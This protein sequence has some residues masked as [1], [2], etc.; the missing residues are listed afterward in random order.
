MST[1]III[2][3]EL[4]VVIGGSRLV[5]WAFRAIAQPLVIGEIV[6]GIALGPSLLGWLSPDLSG[7]LFP[8]PLFLF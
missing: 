4:L 5:G 2:L 1:V 7:A 8:Q 3:I 6:A